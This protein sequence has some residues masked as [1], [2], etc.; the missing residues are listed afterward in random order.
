MQ[1]NRDIV[2]ISTRTKAHKSDDGSSSNEMTSWLGPVG[3]WA[4]QW[5]E[6]MPQTLQHMFQFSHLLGIRQCLMTQNKS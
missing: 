5:A 2:V 1:S 6:E 3:R 4:Q